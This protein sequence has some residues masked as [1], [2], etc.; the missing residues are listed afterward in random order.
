MFSRLSCIDAQRGEAV[1]SKAQAVIVS[2]GWCIQ[3]LVIRQQQMDVF[4]HHMVE[5]FIDRMIVYVRSTFAEQTRKVSD[6]GLR[7]TL[8]VGIDQA[9]QYGV[10]DEADVQRY[11]KYVFTYGPDFATAPRTAW[12]GEILQATNVNG[13]QKMERLGH[14]EF[15]AS[16]RSGA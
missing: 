2:P 3:M 15:L 13:T 14:A 9:A 10:T 1:P 6:D 11:L 8:R 16:M 5:Q 12:A 7:Q 4:R